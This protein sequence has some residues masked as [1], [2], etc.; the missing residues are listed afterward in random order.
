MC[1]ILTGVDPTSALIV[2]GPV[3]C[4]FLLVLV[5]CVGFAMFKKK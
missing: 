5:V 2:I 4:S 3:I 1:V